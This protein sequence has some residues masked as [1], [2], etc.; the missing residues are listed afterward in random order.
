LQKKKFIPFNPQK[1]NPFHANPQNSDAQKFPCKSPKPIADIGLNLAHKSF[2]HDRDDVIRRSFDANVDIFIL[3]GT[4][5]RDSFAVCNMAE[6][7]NKVGPVKMFCTAGVH[8]HNAKLC[9][10]NT[11]PTLR[12]LAQRNEV[13]AIGEC[14]LDFDRNFS[15]PDVQEKVCIHKVLIYGSGLKSN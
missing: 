13:V 8:P 12:K 7:Y 14:G 4:S 11:I 1:S 15:P 2:N 6:R 9:N 5:V 10:E 3:T